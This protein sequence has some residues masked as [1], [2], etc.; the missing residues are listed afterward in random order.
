M[1]RKNKNK[2]LIK[3]VL[4]VSVLVLGLVYVPQY[5]GRFFSVSPPGGGTVGSTSLGTPY[6]VEGQLQDA[7]TGA[8]L[9]GTTATTDFIVSAGPNYPGV[10]RPVV[11]DESQF[12]PNLSKAWESI[13][14]TGTNPVVT[15][16]LSYYPGE[17]IATHSFTATGIGAQGGGYIDDYRL[18]KIPAVPTSGSSNQQIF[19]IGVIP[20]QQSVG[21]ADLNIIVVS[22]SGSSIVATTANGVGSGGSFTGLE[23]NFVMDAQISVNRV[24]R[25]LGTPMKVIPSNN[26]FRI[27]TRYLVAWLGVNKTGGSEYVQANGWTKTDIQPLSGYTFFYRVLPSIDYTRQGVAGKISFLIPH[28]G[29]DDAASVI[30]TYYLFV[31]PQQSVEDAKRLTRSAAASVITSSISSAFSNT[32]LNA[33]IPDAGPKTLTTSTGAR[34][35]LHSNA[36]YWILVHVT[37]F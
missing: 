27:D 20:L 2:G 26:P 9:G 10:N 11:F 29:A 23:K 21:A 35:L 18:I 19:S 13:T 5:A 3:V 30:R 36:N 16:R 32:G 15:T 14:A 4:L 33:L 22:P 31:Q 24:S 8:A 34:G 7:D 1:A 28:Y 25:H 17:I 6:I 12:L 37:N